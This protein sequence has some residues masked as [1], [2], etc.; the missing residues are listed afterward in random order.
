MS[1]AKIRVKQIATEAINQAISEQVADSSNFQSLIEWKTDQNGK[2]AGFMM[3]YAE[4]MRITSRTKNVVESTLKN[5]KETH[6]SIPLGQ[7]LNSA[8]IASFGP[9]VPI[10]LEPQGAVKVE[11]NTKQQE[12]GINMI[13][14]EVYIR[15]VAEVSIIIPFDTTPEAVETEIP[16]S[17]LLVVGNVPTYYYDSKGKAVGDNSGGAPNI[18]IPAPNSSSSNATGNQAPGVST[19]VPSNKAQSEATNSNVEVETTPAR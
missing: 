1:L 11:L 4:N 8:I 18:A 17:Y 10:R 16:V 2:I 15:I 9:K 7:A 12:A 3:N 5:I 19:P 6:E 14:V 13:L